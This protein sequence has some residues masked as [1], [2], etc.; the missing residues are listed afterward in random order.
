MFLNAQI[1]V[2]RC[3]IR[4]CSGPSPTPRVL[5]KNRFPTK[6]RFPPKKKPKIAID[7]IFRLTLNRFRNRFP[8]KKPNFVIGAKLGSFDFAENRD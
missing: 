8:H 7:A 2:C 1:V 5:H 4:C 6:D 3:P